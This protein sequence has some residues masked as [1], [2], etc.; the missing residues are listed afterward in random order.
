MIESCT[1][2]HHIRCHP[3]SQGRKA[4]VSVFLFA[5]FAL[6]LC[7]PLACHSNPPFAFN[8][9]SI[10]THLLHAGVLCAIAAQVAYLEDLGQ[11]SVCLA[12][13]RHPRILGI[14]LNGPDEIKMARMRGGRCRRWRCAGRVRYTI[15][16][17][18]PHLRLVATLA[19]VARGPALC[20]KA[21]SGRPVMCK[22]ARALVAGHLRGPPR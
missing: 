15:E 18:A 5:L 11:R 2:A 13:G 4:L 6:S 21:L 17:D 3:R 1:A 19:I 7:F 14:C 9:R 22:R 16:D 8:K 20:Q 12:L 10:V